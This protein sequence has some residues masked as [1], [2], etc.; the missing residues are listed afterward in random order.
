MG[1]E[2]LDTISETESDEFIKS[3]VENLIP[4]PKV[5]AFLAVEDEPTSSQ[6]PKLYLDPEGDMLL[7]EAFLNDDHSSNF[8]TKSSSTSFNSLL[9]ETNN[10]H[11]SLPEFTTFSNV[12]CDAEYESDSSDDQSCFDKDVLETI[13]SKPLREEEI[14]PMISLRTHDSFLPISSKIDSLLDEFADG[15]KDSLAASE[16]A[17]TN[18]FD[19]RGEELSYNNF[20]IRRMSSSKS[21]S[22]SSIPG[23]IDLRRVSSP[24]NSSKRES[25]LDEI[26]KEESWV[27]RDS[28]RSNSALW[29]ADLS[30]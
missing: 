21:Q 28:I 15:E 25:I 29:D 9:E 20:S 11:N 19:G 18:S 4:I 12:L 14:I 10:F 27:R 17:E 2:H 16:F 8:K 1:D 13:V 6:F 7:F 22:V 30:S 23:R 26:E 5:D 3:G 24:A